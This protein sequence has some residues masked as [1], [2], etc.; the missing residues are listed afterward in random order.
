MFMSFT[1]ALA[2]TQNLPLF[3]RQPSAYPSI[4][5]WTGL[6]LKC[7]LHDSPSSDAPCPRMTLASSFRAI[8]HYACSQWQE[9]QF[10]EDPYIC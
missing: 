6:F 7:Y 4:L 3:Q 10:L 9:Q 8:Q 2:D 1:D 5:L